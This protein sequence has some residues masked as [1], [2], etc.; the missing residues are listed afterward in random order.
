M[1]SS[2]LISGTPTTAGTYAVTASA[3]DGFGLVGTAAFTWTVS[4]S[5]QLTN[6]GNQT[7][8]SD[9]NVSLAI[10]RSGGT[11]PFIWSVTAPGPWGATGLPPGLS[12]DTSTGVISGKPTTAG[13]AKDVTVTV[14]DS[15][16]KSGSTTFTWTI[17]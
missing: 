17:Q 10:S 13:A 15:F 6:P 14:T 7:T 11:E 9:K 5:P 4:A 12:I 2:G 1:A 16:G 3:T 8:K